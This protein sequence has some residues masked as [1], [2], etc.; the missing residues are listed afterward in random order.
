MRGETAVENGVEVVE[1]GGAA[2]PTSLG[3]R[4]N[5]A[6][7]QN[8]LK[9]ASRGSPNHHYNRGEWSDTDNQHFEQNEVQ[10]DFPSSLQNE[11]S[12]DLIT[13]NP[14]YPYYKESTSNTNGM[15]ASVQADDSISVPT[16]KFLGSPQ[17]LGYGIKATENGAMLSEHLNVPQRYDPKD[18]LFRLSSLRLNDTANGDFHDLVQTQKFSKPIQRNGSDIVTD[19]VNALFGSSNKGKDLSRS[20]QAVAPNPFYKTLASEADLFSRNGE[21]LFQVN[22]TQDNAPNTDDNKSFKEGFD[23]FSLPTNPVDPFPSPLPRNLFNVPSLDDPFGPTPSKT[24]S[25]SPLTNRPSEFKLDTP[26]STGLVKKTPPKVPPAVPRKPQIKPRDLFTTPQGSKEKFLEPTSF[27]QASSLSSSPSISPAD[28][29]HVQTFKRPPRPVPRTRRPK[30]EKP[31]APERPPPPAHSTKLEPEVPE[32]HTA[33]P[34]PPKPPP[35]PVLK[36]LPKPVLPHKPKKPESKPLEPENFVFE[37]V[38]LIGQEHC[39]EDWPEDSPELDPDFK[40]SG[41]FKLR[42]ESMKAKMESDGGSSEDPDGTFGYVKKKDRKLRMSLLS[43]RSS[44]DKYSDDSMEGKSNMLPS[45]QKTPKEFGSNDYISTGDDEDH[46]SLDYK[47][48]STKAKVSHLFRRAS[49]ASST[50]NDK[51]SPSK[52]GDHKKSSKR[53]NTIVRRQS[54]D[55]VLDEDYEDGEKGGHR[56]R[57]NSKVKIKFVPQRG[58]AISLEKPHDEPKGAHGYTSRKGSKDKSVEECG[59][60]GYTP[61]DNLQVESYFS[62]NNNNLHKL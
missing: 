25:S 61:R 3:S 17:E 29:T 44:K 21:D 36:P 6:T 23:V 37:D 49:D 28:I 60:H 42:R 31:P 58:F 48:K 33:K 4:P 41:T 9:M 30:A 19:D 34:E 59:A 52:D 54:A 50:Y 16:M 47:K 14:F 55:S 5:V 1:H 26:E 53:Q 7:L 24:M 12:A 32:A 51:H 20:P 38:L 43:R 57:R 13:E 39:V 10:E 45:R 22:D 18:E 40:P 56:Q 11:N 15:E 8:M 46:Y 2:A 27:S 35:K 62:F